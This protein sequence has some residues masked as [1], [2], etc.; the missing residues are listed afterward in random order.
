MAGN[1]SALKQTID[2]NVKQ[3]GAQQITGPVL[4]SV[5][6]Q[7]VSSIGANATFA[8]IATPDTDPGTPDQ[9]VFYFATEPG[10]YVNF[11][12]KEVKAGITLLT[13]Q[14]GKWRDLP[15]IQINASDL[16]YIK[17]NSIDTPIWGEEIQADSSVEKIYLLNGSTQDNTNYISNIYLLSQFS[18]KV[19]VTLDEFGNG[20]YNACYVDNDDNFVAGY[21]KADSPSKNMPKIISIFLNDIPEGAT[22]LCVTSRNTSIPYL[23]DVESG[24]KTIRNL[25]SD[26]DSA[27]FQRNS[28]IISNSIVGFFTQDGTY[29]ENTNYIT[30]FYRIDDGAKNFFIEGYDYGTG[31]VSYAFSKTND[32]TAKPEGV[33]KMN[34]GSGPEKVLF[35]F[36]EED[37]PK[38]CTYV[39][40]TRRKDA[41]KWLYTSLPLHLKPAARKKYKA[42]VISWTDHIPPQGVAFVDNNVERT[43][44]MLQVITHFDESR[45]IMLCFG[46]NGPNGMFGLRG[47]SIIYRGNHD[48][49]DF[50]EQFTEAYET[51]GPWNIAA[52]NNPVN[53]SEQN[54]TGGYHALINP[55]TDVRAPSASNKGFHYFADGVELNLY[56]IV[57]TDNIKCINKVNI[58]A[59][60]TMNYETNTAR[61]VLEYNDIYEMG[62]LD[63][64]IHI[65]AYF[66]ALEDINITLHYGLQTDRFN[67]HIAYWLDSGIIQQDNSQDTDRLDI[68]G[69]PT[70]VS[71]TNN[72]GVS[73]NVRMY[74]EGA[75]TGD[76]TDG[77]KAFCLTYGVSNAKT[78]H[79][80]YGNGKS[81]NLKTGESNFYRGYIEIVNNLIR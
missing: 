16:D 50:P 51:V 27:N 38:E 20:F 77:Y 29:Q 3:N 8:G 72:D 15:I 60:N 61:E 42:R 17:K 74:N 10:T 30:D 73:E 58:C 22:K 23:Y 43:F 66:T 69:L 14:S 76:R 47:W 55:E 24:V 63:N 57:Y 36:S 37:I 39:V 56:D 9:N 40:V 53:D 32:S 2:S 65:L 13:N 7:I 46:L 48:F 21:D 45:D 54:F 31:I 80:V 19:V 62:P 35:V 28:A 71:A 49:A 4:N 34:S 68:V 12:G 44:N 41:E 5:L 64:K 79:W 33:V 26:I 1:Y 25:R 67:P 52:I 81:Q 75:M 6:N 11:G 70:L 78:Y 59:Y 18:N